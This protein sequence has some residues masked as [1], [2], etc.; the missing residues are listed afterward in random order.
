[1]DRTATAAL[2]RENAIA[3]RV[4]LGIVCLLAAPPMTLLVLLELTLGLRSEVFGTLFVESTISTRLIMG[5]CLVAAIVLVVGGLALVVL[6]ARLGTT[7]WSVFWWTV[8]SYVG[9][10]VLAAALVART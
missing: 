8:G 9:I 1:M 6:S 2:V 10:L 3:S 5:M 7:W 4:V